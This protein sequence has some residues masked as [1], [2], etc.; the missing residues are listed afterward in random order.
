MQCT[1]FTLYSVPSSVVNVSGVQRWM[2]RRSVA[3]CSLLQYIHHA[4]HVNLNYQTDVRPWHTFRMFLTKEHTGRLDYDSPRVQ[5]ITSII[6]CEDPYME[7]HTPDSDYPSTALHDAF[8]V[9]G[10]NTNFNHKCR[11]VLLKSNVTES[12]QMKVSQWI[13]N[14]STLMRWYANLY[15]CESRRKINWYSCTP[16]LILC[17]FLSNCTKE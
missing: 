12:K 14:H 1:Q 17:C 8:L 2:H 13:G 11:T 5:Y 15:N 10:E 9:W 16:L 4:V 6:L 7:I 3:G